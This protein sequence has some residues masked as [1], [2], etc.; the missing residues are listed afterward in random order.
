MKMII[1]NGSLISDAITA[2]LLGSPDLS[3]I[4]IRLKITNILINS[5]NPKKKK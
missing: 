3:F 2:S 1:I 5:L 4:G